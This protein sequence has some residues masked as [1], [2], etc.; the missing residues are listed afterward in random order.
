VVAVD[1]LFDVMTLLKDQ[2]PHLQ[3]AGLATD[4]ETLLQLGNALAQGGVTRICAI[5]EMTSPAAGWHHDGR[6]SLLDLVNMVDIESST[7]VAANQST[8][9]EL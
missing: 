4:P 2:R 6:F 7:E 5:G 8:G 1:S 3:T 9:Y